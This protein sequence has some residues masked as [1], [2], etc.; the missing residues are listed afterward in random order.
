MASPGQ[1]LTEEQRQQIISKLLAERRSKGG[2]P[3]NVSENESERAKRIQELLA[4]R[5]AARRHPSNALALGREESC[6]ALLS[7]ASTCSLQSSRPAVR[8]PGGGIASPLQAGTSRTAA[9]STAQQHIF[10]RSHQPQQQTSQLQAAAQR[11][12]SLDAGGPVDVSRLWETPNEQ[13]SALALEEE[14][15]ASY[16]S[17]PHSAFSE[18][19]SVTWH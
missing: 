1:A 13:G 12:L 5:A 18:Y 10:A 9:Q 4:S 8:D 15:D 17:T 19:I 16:C 2:G 6:D 3:P 11:R 14:Y 7:P